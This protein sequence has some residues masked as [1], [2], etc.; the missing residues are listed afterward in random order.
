M[1]GSIYCFNC[2]NEPINALT[3]NGM[4][5]GSVSG[6]ATSGATVYTPVALPVAR[7]RHGDGSPVPV[8]GNDMPTPIQINWDSYT[9]QTTVDLTGLPNVSID[10]DLIL[11]IALNQMTLM[12]TRGFVLLSQPVS[13]SGAGG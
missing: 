4:N 5:A 8:F 3:V 7:A 11:Y 13:P 10:D 12:N 9:M 6:W 2:Y 1:P